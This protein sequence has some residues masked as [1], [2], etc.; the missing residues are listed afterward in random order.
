M[1]KHRGNLLSLLVSYASNG[2]KSYRKKKLI[3]SNLRRCVGYDKLYQN[4]NSENSNKVVWQKSVG[5]I[6]VANCSQM[7]QTLLVRLHLLPMF[8]L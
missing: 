3:R 8:A 1:L 5:N 6:Y 4:W 7:F 2:H